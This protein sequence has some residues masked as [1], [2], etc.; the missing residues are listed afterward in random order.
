MRT[1]GVSRDGSLRHNYDPQEFHLVP[2]GYWNWKW[3]STRANYSTYERELL[4][5]T[6]LFSGQIRL[7]GSYSIVWSCDQESTESFRKGAPPEI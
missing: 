7:F 4:L 1:V 2:I 3:S 6:L 5:G